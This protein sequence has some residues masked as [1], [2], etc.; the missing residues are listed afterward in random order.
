[1]IGRI[2]GFIKTPAGAAIVFLLAMFTV[3]YFIREYRERN[4]DEEEVAN[5]LGQMSPEAAERDPN[6]PLTSEWVTEG[7]LDKFNPP[8]DSAAPAPRPVVQQDAP[9]K[10]AALPQ[11]VHLY[12]PAKD[13]PTPAD[14]IKPPRTFAP[15]GTLIPCQL[16]IT[17]DSS[18]L[19]T[20][21]VGV[22]TDDVWHNQK[23]IVPAGTEVHSFA[24]R[25]R[26]RDRVEVTRRVEVRLARRSRGEDQR[27]RLGSRIRSRQRHVR[28]H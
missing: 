13:K 28:A 2:I 21:V 22:V 18:S 3:F 12:N 17:V 6:A 4:P 11:L 23:L 24:K 19:E 16:V 10:S 26:V 15:P 14:P 1:V 9:A 7:K 8:A 20:P 5:R 27:H 25:G